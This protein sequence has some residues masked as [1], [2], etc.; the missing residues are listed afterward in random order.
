MGL[1]WDLK[2]SQQLRLAYQFQYTEDL[3]GAPRERDE[4]Y[5]VWDIGTGSGAIPVAIA[6]ELR[7]R[8]YGAAVHFFVSDVSSDARDVATLNVVAHGLAHLFT[9]AEG[10]LTDVTPTPTRP[11]DL[12]VANLPY[13]P[14]AMLPQ[15]P[16]AASFEPATALDGGPDGLDVIRRLLPRAPDAVAPGGAVLLEI[17]SDQGEAV[18][19]AAARALPLWRCTIYPD[20]SGSHR[21]AELERPGV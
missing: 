18:T 10:D 16:V 6:L 1:L 17:G 19:D 11:A 8:R 3:T 21:V 9:F 20:L 4:P 12:V 15:L 5:L 2:R 7:R 13:I 14:A